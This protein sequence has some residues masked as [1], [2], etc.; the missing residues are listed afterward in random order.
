MLSL[1]KNSFGYQNNFIEYRNVSNFKKDLEKFDYTIY[2]G[3][4]GKLFRNSLEEFPKT[5]FLKSSNKVD[6]VTNKLFNKYKNQIKIGI[7]W[8]SKASI[9]EEKSLTLEQLKPILLMNNKFNFFN[10]QYSDSSNEI[11]SFKKKNNKVVI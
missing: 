10:M 1:F 6:D 9:G 7:S 2:A 11:N 4:L 5:N 3:S 8:I